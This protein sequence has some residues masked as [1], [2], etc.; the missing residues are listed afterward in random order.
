MIGVEAAKHFLFFDDAWTAEKALSAGMV[1]ALCDEDKLT[2]EVLTAARR[3]ASG[4]TFAYGKTKA[5]LE[6][7][8]SNS[9]A[10]QLLA[11][12]QAGLACGGTA[13][14]R[15]AVKASVEKRSPIFSGR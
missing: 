8:A 7:S 13:D 11:E 5:L 10:K 12:Q 6:Q 3:L 14:G 2:S 15:E 9:L 1:T 4:P